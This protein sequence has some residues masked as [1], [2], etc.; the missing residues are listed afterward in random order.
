MD[1]LYLAAGLAAGLAIGIGATKKNSKILFYKNILDTC[2][3]KNIKIYS[4][5]DEISIDEFIN[6][7]NL[8]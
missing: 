3:K 5:S 4:G 8:K 6:D 1:S 2:S 7:L